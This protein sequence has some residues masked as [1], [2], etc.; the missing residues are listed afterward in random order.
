MGLLVMGLFIDDSSADDLPGNDVDDELLADSD[1]CF[2]LING[3]QC[4]GN[5]FAGNEPKSIYFVGFY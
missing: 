2:I 3:V 1:K 5:S 4:F